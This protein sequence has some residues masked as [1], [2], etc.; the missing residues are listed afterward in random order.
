M[1]TRKLG[2]LGAAAL[3]IVATASLANAHSFPQ[4]ENPPAGATLPAS[5]PR[6]TIEF[7]APIEK[8]FTSVKVLDSSGRDQAEGAPTVAPDGRTLSVDLRKLP[9]GDYTVKWTVVCIDSHHT[10]GSYQFTIASAR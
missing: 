4:S 3:A 7:D 5:P 9:P 8:L 1:S 10:Q 6:V 2:V